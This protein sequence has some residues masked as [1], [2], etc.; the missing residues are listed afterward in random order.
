MKET[1]RF[2]GSI[3][4]IG[5]VELRTFGQSI[6]LTAEDAATAIKGGAA[7]LPED[8]FK[9]SFPQD[10]DF[11]KFKNIGAQIVTDADLKQPTAPHVAAKLAFIAARAK[12]HDTLRSIM[13]TI[14]LVTHPVVAPSSGDADLIAAEVAHEKRTEGIS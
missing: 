4:N 7:I 5:N 12:A 6:E 8:D 14:Q 3:C 10:S 2:V 11:A 1:Y 13:S 9:K